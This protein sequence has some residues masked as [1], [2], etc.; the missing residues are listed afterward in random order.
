M[1]RFCEGCGQPVNGV[2]KHCPRCGYKSS[3]ASP[4]GVKT[5]MAPKAFTP[6]FSSASELALDLIASGLADFQTVKPDPNWEP[7][8]KKEF[9]AD[10][11]RVL[12]VNNL[13]K[14][15]ENSQFALSAV[16]TEQTLAEMLDELES[17]EVEA[18]QTRVLDDGWYIEVIHLEDSAPAELRLAK[19]LQ[20]NYGGEISVIKP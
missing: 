1:N 15:P 7:F 3:F 4:S 6:L 18:T 17:E 2:W 14:N 13:D 16:I 8:W 9:T 12:F 10:R 11:Y 19:E 5:K 20:A